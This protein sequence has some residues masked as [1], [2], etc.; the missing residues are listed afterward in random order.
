MR[1]SCCWIFFCIS[2]FGFYNTGFIPPASTLYEMVRGLYTFS[3]RRLY[4]PSDFF[5]NS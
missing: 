1:K 4:S 2:R 5:Y 3:A